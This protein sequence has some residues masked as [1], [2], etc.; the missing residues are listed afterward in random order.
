MQ[1][2]VHA[3]LAALVIVCTVVAVP[4]KGAAVS[5]VAARLRLRGGVDQ[6]GMN[7]GF[8]NAK[9]SPMAIK[10]WLFR[11]R[12]SA[13]ACLLCEIKCACACV[14]VLSIVYCVC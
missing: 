4:A 7:D 11:T 2:R 6:Y 1:A 14:C 3:A 8:R 13:R 12:G 10:R 9:P 5:S